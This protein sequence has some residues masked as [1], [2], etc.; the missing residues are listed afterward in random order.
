MSAAPRL[1][2]AADLID[3]WCGNCHAETMVR[4]DRLCPS[5]GRLTT[6]TSSL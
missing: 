3:A 4:A 6:T 2:P 5:C 1:E